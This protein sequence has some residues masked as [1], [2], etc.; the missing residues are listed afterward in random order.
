MS[1]ARLGKFLAAARDLWCH[2]DLQK[3]RS[4]T[5]KDFRQIALSFPETAESSHMHHPDFRVAGKIFATLAHPDKAWGMVKLTPE[6]QG[7]FV[8]DDP[9]AFVPVKGGWGQKGATHV[10]LKAAKKTI[11][12][13]ALAAAWSNTAPK[14]LAAEFEKKRK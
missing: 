5:S 7:E 8:H 6:Q 4:M 13:T 1:S 2:A 9:E 11:V 12:R 14:Q 3:G 10:R